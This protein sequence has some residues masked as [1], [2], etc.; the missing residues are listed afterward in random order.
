MTSSVGTLVGLTVAIV[1]G[2]AAAAKARHPAAFVVAV[3]SALPDALTPW[4]RSVAWLTIGLEAVAAVGCL[5]PF[6]RRIGLTLAALLLVSFALVA[7]RSATG[8]RRTPCSCF[9]RGTAVLGWRHVVR[10]TLLGAA[11]ATGALAPPV[12]NT[13]LPTELMPLAIVGSLLL[14][15]TAVFVDD[16]AR[17]LPAR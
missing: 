1:L 8:A 2:S 11:A 6:T 9:G 13:V 4:C 7:L 12:A 15:G 16:L 3:R 10:N 5:V 17:A 14:A